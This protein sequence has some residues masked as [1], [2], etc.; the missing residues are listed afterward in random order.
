M[1]KNYQVDVRCPF[2]GSDMVYED[3]YDYDSGHNYYECGECGETFTE[4]DISY[5]DQCGEQVINDEIISVDG[6]VFCSEECRDKYL[7]EEQ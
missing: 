7:D 4:D 2:C 3:G 5:C 6:M 1:E